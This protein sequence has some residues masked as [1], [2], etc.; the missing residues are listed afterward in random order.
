MGKVALVAGVDAIFMEVHNNVEEA[1]CDGP[2]QWP[3][4]KLEGLL[5]EFLRYI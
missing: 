4:D 3:L 5:E 2:T 1:K